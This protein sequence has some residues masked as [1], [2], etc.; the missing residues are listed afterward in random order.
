MISE[1]IGVLAF[2]PVLLLWP[3]KPLCQLITPERQLETLLTLIVTLLASYLALRFLPWPF[4]FIVVILFWCAVRLP[5][6]EA[7][8]LFFLNA[9]FISLLLA[10]DWSTARNDLLLGGQH[11]C[12]FCWC[13]CRAV[14]SLVM[15]AFQRENT[16]SA[17]AKP[18][19]ATPWS[20]PPS[21]WRWYRRKAAGNRSTS[22]CAARWASRRRS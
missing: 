6:F 16:T 14:M 13:C 20:I 4:T 18:A 11:G 8:L 21:A 9:S 17:K 1:V 22:R 2:G 10:L 3:D 7:F 5:K 19:S 12:R 15:D